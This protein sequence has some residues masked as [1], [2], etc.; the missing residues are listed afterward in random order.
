MCAWRSEKFF[1]PQWPLA[2]FQNVGKSLDFD[3]HD[4]GS[5]IA[6]S[7]AMVKTGG[8]RSVVRTAAF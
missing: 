7:S 4:G 6:R 1:T 8:L 3:S 2:L 5:L